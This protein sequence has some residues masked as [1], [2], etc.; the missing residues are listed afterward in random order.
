MLDI[1]SSAF[2]TSNVANAARA[3]DGSSGRGYDLV[4]GL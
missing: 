2:C 1:S 4:E 3:L